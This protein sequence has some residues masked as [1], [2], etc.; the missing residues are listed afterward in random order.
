MNLGVRGECRC[1]RKIDCRGIKL[2]GPGE[3]VGP[4]QGDGLG[5]DQDISGSADVVGENLTPTRSEVQLARVGGDDGPRSDRGHRGL[6]HRDRR[7]EDIADTDHDSPKD[8]DRS[9]GVVRVL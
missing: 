9:V 4:G 2:V 7:I 3:C 1:I 6:A 5:G 8:L